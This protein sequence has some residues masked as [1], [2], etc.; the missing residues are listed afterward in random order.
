VRLPSLDTPARATIYFPSAQSPNDFMT[1]MLRTTGPPAALGPG[2]RATIASLDPSVPVGS[3]LTLDQVVADS[4]GS[5]R[6]VLLLVGFFGA[7]ALALA[8]IGLF[9]VM[10]YAVSQRTSEV[11]MRMALGAGRTDVLGLVVGD[12]MRLAAAGLAVGLVSGLA[13]SELL[14]SQLFE[15]RPWDPL[16]LSGVAVT[17][18]AVSLAALAGPAWRAASVDPAHALRAE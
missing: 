16:A 11:G 15:V 6:F 18:V 13:V 8:G 4:L 12:G 3:V 14:A 7:A 5:R 1:L 17:V 9:G 2:L 10:A